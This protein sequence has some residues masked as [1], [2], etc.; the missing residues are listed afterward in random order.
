[1]VYRP[2]LLRCVGAATML[3]AAVRVA[4]VTTRTAAPEAA[5]SRDYA[6]IHFPFGNQQGLVQGHCIGQVILDR[7]QFTAPGRGPW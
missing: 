4:L 1:M 2:W 3:A 5:I 6:G 7:L